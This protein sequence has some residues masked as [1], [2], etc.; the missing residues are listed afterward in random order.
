MFISIVTDSGS[1]FSK[2]TSIIRTIRS[3]TY[4]VSD[5][6]C[7][8]VAVRRLY[9]TV[10]IRISNLY[11]AFISAVC[12][13]YRVTCT[14]ADNTLRDAVCLFMGNDCPVIG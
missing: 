3:F 8:S 1:N 4:I 12:L 11:P 10:I 13:L 2:Y 5:S 14:K 6:A 7:Q 9:D